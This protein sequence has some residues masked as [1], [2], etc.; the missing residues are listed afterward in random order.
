MK[1]NRKSL[2]ISLFLLITIILGYV[3]AS[4][5][6]EIFKGPELVIFILI[7]IIGLAAL[8]MAFKR[9]KEERDGMQTDDEL[10]NRIKYKAGY[11]A[12]LISMYA[13]F[14]IYLLKDKFPDV[15]SML[16]GGILVSAVIFFMTKI[17]VKRTFNE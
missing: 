11:H 10:S 5:E 14:F 4:T 1:K 15:E 13:W 2:L 8:L 7:V 9:D 6:I 3:V 17:Y 16:G 12:Y